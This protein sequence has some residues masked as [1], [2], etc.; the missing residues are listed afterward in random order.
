MKNKSILALLGVLVVL[1]VA[2][3][4]IN[5]ARNVT[6]R[7]RPFCEVDT[8][9]VDEIQIIS[10]EGEVV[11]KR[12]GSSWRLS[13]PL[14]YPA[15]G[16]YVTNVLSKIKDM[17]I[18]NLVTTDTSEDTLYGFD[19]TAIEVSLF[20]GGNK[21]AHIIVGKA[22]DNYRHTYCRR[23]GEDAIYR[24]KGAYISQFKRKTK[25]WR[26][27]SILELDRDSINRIDYQYPK[28]SFSLVKADTVWTI[29]S[30]RTTEPAEDRFVNQT[31]SLVSRFR[32]FDFVDGDSVNV[33]DFSRPE[34]TV[35][36]YTDDGSTY[37]MSLIPKDNEE[38]RYVIK[39]DGVDNTLFV[40]YKGTA[41]ALMKRKDDFKPVEKEKRKS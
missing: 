38:N 6:T 41:N 23:Q 33:Y 5:S 40:V 14:D 10:P 35:T 34:L 28:E 27:K 32:T 9:K 17:T 31:I 36:I 4:L 29:E 8:S 18:E 7:P 26:D 24:I 11:L 3:L 39:K 20:G 25:D 15:E 21:L 2:Y 13:S 16:N 19:S 30:D 12:S 37:K 22:A 1:I